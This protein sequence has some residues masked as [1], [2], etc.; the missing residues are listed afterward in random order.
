ME[1][2]TTWRSSEGARWL[3]WTVLY[4]LV[5]YGVSIVFAFTQ[6]HEIGFQ[7]PFPFSGGWGSLPSFLVPA[8]VAFVI[9]VRFRTWWW[10][11]GPLTALALPAALFIIGASNRALDPDSQ[12]WAV[13]FSLFFVVYGALFSLI[14]IAGV[15]WGKRRGASESGS[16][17][18]SLGGDAS[19]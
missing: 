19:P 16:I 11:L 8:V 10:G 6:T 17:W 15:W 7:L 9:G 4:A 1:R 12:G 13:V 3:G 5:V 2:V 18:S 14:G